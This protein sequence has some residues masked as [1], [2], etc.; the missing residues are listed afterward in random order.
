VSRDLRRR[1]VAAGV[2]AEPI[3]VVR[4]DAA[5]FIGIRVQ[6]TLNAVLGDL[7]FR[8]PDWPSPTSRAATWS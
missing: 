3:G 4:F 5:G 7:G 2:K 6:D 1:V 8:E